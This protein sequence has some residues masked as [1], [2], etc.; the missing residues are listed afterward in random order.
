MDGKDLF[1][2]TDQSGTGVVLDQLKVKS[3]SDVAEIDE[4]Q[5]FSCSLIVVS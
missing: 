5:D 3:L 4:D 2:G 1:E